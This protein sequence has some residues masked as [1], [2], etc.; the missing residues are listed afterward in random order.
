MRQFLG[1]KTSITLI[2]LDNSAVPAALDASVVLVALAALFALT[3]LIASDVLTALDA[4]AAAEVIVE[5]IAGDD[6]EAIVAAVAA[7]EVNT[8]Y[9]SYESIGCLRRST[10]PLQ[11][12][13]QGLFS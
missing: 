9:F 7:A 10:C 6:A 4:E 8:F 2:R 12:L 1:I 3:V 5:A 13:L 11:N